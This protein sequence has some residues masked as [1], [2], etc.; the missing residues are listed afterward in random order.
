M[1]EAE[2]RAIL[3]EAGCKFERRSDPNDDCRVKSGWW[4]DDVFLAKEVKLAYEFMY[5]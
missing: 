5:A 4:Q 2:K 3:I 1:S